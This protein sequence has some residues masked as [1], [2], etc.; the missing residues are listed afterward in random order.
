MGPGGTLG[1]T[2]AGN[3]W[4]KEPDDSWR[5]KACTPVSLTGLKFMKLIREHEEAHDEHEVAKAFFEQGF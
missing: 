4:R 3:G 2:G 5:G 1:T